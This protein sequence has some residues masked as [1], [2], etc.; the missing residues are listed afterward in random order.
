M[1]ND[2]EKYLTGSDAGLDRMA[3]W[4]PVAIPDFAGEF[5]GYQFG[6]NAPTSQLDAAFFTTMTL[7]NV[8][9][10][11][12]PAARAD[13]SGV[14]EGIVA[15]LASGA[16]ALDAT[17]SN[18]LGGIM[19]GVGSSV[20]YAQAMSDFAQFI[21]DFIGAQ[22]EDND[23]R[24]FNAR[25]LCVEL[26]REAGPTT[27]TG[28]NWFDMK[29]TRKIAGKSD[30]QNYVWPPDADWGLTLKAHKKL[31]CDW[32]DGGGGNLA[33]K[34]TGCKGSF[35]LFPIYM[36]LF[37]NRALGS[38]GPLV[39]M[40]RGMERA[41]GGGAHVWKTMSEM[42]GSLL[43]DP[44]MNLQASAESVWWRMQGF[45]QTVWGRS[46]SETM[47]RDEI[48]IDPE[49]NENN[50]GTGFYYT[51]GHLIGAY[52]N[53]AEGSLTHP[54]LTT[55]IVRIHEQTAP[56]S[57]GGFG[58]SLADYN[59]VVSATCQFLSLRVATL[60]R[61]AFCQRAVESGI[62]DL[63][64][65]MSARKAVIA[66]AAGKPAPAI[67]KA[68]GFQPGRLLL[69]RPTKSPP[70]GKSGGGLVAVAGLS[71]AAFAMRRR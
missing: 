68:G 60:R 32:G 37:G 24:R 56:S 19:K 26:L 64:P 14:I 13:L 31:S 34:D 41:P 38:P 20:A 9:S 54:I 8:W 30:P 39:S 27:W 45:L 51:P 55:T 44:I 17:I 28:D 53:T 40:R 43:T 63:M 66:S 11:M 59:T 18:V 6:I 22:M 12:P 3:D 36:P 21:V 4:T 69:T 62:V 52:T 10:V 65:E 15:N 16:G 49:F 33:P 1:A 46:L 57:F 42:Q 67:G 61:Q 50:D 58:I 2:L 23:T 71:L 48:R 47:E 25:M 7:R 5:G 29:Y 35:S 70:P